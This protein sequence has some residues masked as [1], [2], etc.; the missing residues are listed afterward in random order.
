MCRNFSLNA[1]LW[2]DLLRYLR[3]VKIWDITIYCFSVQSLAEV[4]LETMGY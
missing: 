1:I 3:E 2:T 4:K